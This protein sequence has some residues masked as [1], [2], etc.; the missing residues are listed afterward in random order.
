[1]SD[2][3]LL[4][5]PSALDPTALAYKDWFHLNL[6][7]HAG[8][9]VGLINASLHGAPSNARA[10]AV[11]TALVHDPAQGW[12][13]NVDIQGIGESTVLPDG[14]LLPH[15]ALMLDPSRRTLHASAR[16]PQ[17]GLALRATANAAARPLR[18]ELTQDFGSGW[19]GWFV[20]P[21]VR[22][23][24]RLELE[25][26][27]FDLAVWDAYHDHNWGRWFWGEDIG[28]EWGAFSAAPP[29]PHIVLA[30]LTDRLHRR[31]QPAQLMVVQDG[32]TRIF[33]PGSVAVH[34]G[35]RADV[36]LRRV[37]GALAALHGDRARAALPAH[38][39]V[40]A[41]SGA[42]WLRLSFSVRAAAQ[43]ILGEPTRPGYAFIHE[44]V[45][46]FDATGRVR[47]REIA[48]QGLAVFEYV[49]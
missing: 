27:S 48:T 22:V 29:G 41:V 5:L 34:L 46:A 18:V 44:L 17:D 33:L 8:G 36:R 13:G 42:D 21:R 10:R 15:A 45:G 11:G 37:P 23:A 43:L 16:M 14:I 32:Q 26:R 20:V 38:V 2:F 1:V 28:W 9:R 24:G 47:E 6:F 25:D 39:S 12:F 4:R 30:R 19:I 7:D 31:V 3:D 35:G 40:E 49:T